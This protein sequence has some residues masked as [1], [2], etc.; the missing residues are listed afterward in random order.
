MEGL[1]L[2]NERHRASGADCFAINSTI[3]LL[4][5]F[6]DLAKHAEAVAPDFDFASWIMVPAHWHFAQ[7]QSGKVRNVE[8]FDVETKS[9][10][11]AGLDYGTARAQA[12]RHVQRLMTVGGIYASPVFSGGV[13]YIAST[14]GSVYALI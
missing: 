13:L 8:Q 9:I 3:D 6:L 7:S 11:G 4:S 2:L 10:D 1:F 12:K 14:D 5:D